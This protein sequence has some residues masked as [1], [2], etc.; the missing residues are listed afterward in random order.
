MR[1]IRAEEL[2]RPTYSALVMDLTSLGT[3]L[4]RA[5][6]LQLASPAATSH[7]RQ[8]LQVGDFHTLQ[9]FEVLS[10][11]IC[12]D[13]FLVD[14]RALNAFQ[15]ARELLAMLKKIQMEQYFSAVIFPL[16]SYEE[17]AQSVIAL[18]N[19]ILENAPKSLLKTDRGFLE[20]L[21]GSN[22]TMGVD[23]DTLVDMYKRQY[24]LERPDFPSNLPK[25][26]ATT[27]CPSNASLSI[28]KWREA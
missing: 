1:K 20:E 3:V 18:N 4:A 2:N 9:L 5:E 21:F 28:W 10:N 6:N 27:E 7:Y 11:L 15:G 24:F 23:D 13:Q 26:F 22:E 14:Y 25:H 16:T 8:K 19:T 12:F 17:A